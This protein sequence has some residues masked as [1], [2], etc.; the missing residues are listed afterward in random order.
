MRFLYDL[1]SFKKIFQ[2]HYQQTNQRVV[3]LFEIEIVKQKLNL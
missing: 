3:M 1:V 2:E